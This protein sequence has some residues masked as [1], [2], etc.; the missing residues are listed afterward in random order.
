MFM[1]LLFPDLG[2]IKIIPLAFGTMP[3]NQPSPWDTGDNHPSGRAI[4]S[5]GSL[6]YGRSEAMIPR[7]WVSLFN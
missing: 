2:L 1:F 5:P 7:M 3:T 4:I 6:H